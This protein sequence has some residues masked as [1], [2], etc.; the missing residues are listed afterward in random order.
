MIW[1][2]AIRDHRHDPARRADRT[3]LSNA[4]IHVSQE[5]TLSSFA[6]KTDLP[7]DHFERA[8]ELFTLLLVITILCLLMWPRLLTRIAALVKRL[9]ARLYGHGSWGVRRFLAD[10]NRRYPSKPRPL[11]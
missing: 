1:S 4:L 10:L 2:G 5:I 9:A 3:V 6:S 8:F 7:D 11:R